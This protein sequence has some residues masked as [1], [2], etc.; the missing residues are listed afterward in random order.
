[1][2]FAWLKKNPPVAQIIGVIM[3]AWA[4]IPANPYGYY[5]LLRFVVCGVFIYLAVK[6]YELKKIGWVWALGITAAI[7]NPVLR[8]HL[9]REIWSL[10]NIATIALLIVTVWVLHK[11]CPSA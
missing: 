1:M 11:K 2:N 6:A 10:V 9:T 5:I 7:Y 3:L 8:T 4:L